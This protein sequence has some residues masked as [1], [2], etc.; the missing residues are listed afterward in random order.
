MAVPA[1]LASLPQAADDG[2]GEE[3]QEPYAVII[4]E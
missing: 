2:R 3:E 1:A 4:D